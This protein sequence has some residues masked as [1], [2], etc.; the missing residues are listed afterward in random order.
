MDMGENDPIQP[1]K[2][3]DTN[4]TEAKGFRN[5][6][7]QF[8]GVI[9]GTLAVT[10]TLA[11]LAIPSTREAVWQIGGE[12]RTEQTP[13]K[14]PIPQ[15]GTVDDSTFPEILKQH[16]NAIF[17]TNTRIDPYTFGTIFQTD[18]SNG[19]YAV[20]LRNY[21][22]QCEGKQSI[23]RPV[24]SV[25]NVKD[26]AGKTYV[27]LSLNPT[28]REI[29]RNARNIE[30]EHLPPRT[31]LVDSQPGID[32]FVGKRVCLAGENGTPVVSAIQVSG[33][34]II[35]PI[36]FEEAADETQDS[37]NILPLAAIV[38]LL[39][40]L[41]ILERGGAF[42]NLLL[43]TPRT[44]NES[45]Q[46]VS[47]INTIELNKRDGQ[48]RFDTSP[49]VEDRTGMSLTAQEDRQRDQIE[50]MVKNSPEWDQET[51]D[52]TQGRIKRIF[53]RIRL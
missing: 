53:A 52:V 34:Q 48:R 44:K 10:A 21:R 4:Q 15:K 27:P 24:I 49:R 37:I 29:L 13:S 6:N 40:G 19:R 12:D 9:V 42:D 28:M 51:Q 30:I 20:D 35:R 3:P 14:I 26:N 25:R 50:A 46:K 36:N 45:T 11:T 33:R 43:R 47:R 31:I 39:G 18:F 8:G 2:Q 38:L 16:P 17:I 23:N 41:V 1:I 5:P 7:I 32:Q 22:V